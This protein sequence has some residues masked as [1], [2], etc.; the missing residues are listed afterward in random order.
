MIMGVLGLLGCQS[1]RV[2]PEEVDQEITIALGEVWLGGE[3]ARRIPLDV[4]QL[5]TDEALT[6]TAGEG[7]VDLRWTPTATGEVSLSLRADGATI[8]LTA[9]VTEPAVWPAP[10]ATTIGLESLD[11]L[12]ATA[13][14][15]GGW[16]V[17]RLRVGVAGLGVPAFGNQ[18]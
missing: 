7:H 13:V 10:L 1:C 5:T 14:V 15:V 9:T 18:L 4:D 3:V 6:V 17:V 11:S 12:E 8:I 2:G 16:C